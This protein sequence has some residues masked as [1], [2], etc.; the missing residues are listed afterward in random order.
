MYA[1]QK[2]KIGF[3]KFKILYDKKSYVILKYFLGKQSNYKSYVNCQD[4]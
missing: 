1:E 4:N 2:V 3:K